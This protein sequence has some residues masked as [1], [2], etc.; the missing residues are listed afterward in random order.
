MCVDY[1]MLNSQ[2]IKD[3]FPL[4]HPEDL[5]DRMRDC[6]YFTKI[7]LLWGYWQI[8]VTPDH[9]HKTAFVTP[10]GQF[11]FRVLPFGLTNAPAT[12]QRYVAH[13]LCHD[14]DAGHVSQFID[15]ICVHSRTLDEH[16]VHVSSVLNTL[17]K[18]QLRTKPSKCDFF[19]K[20]IGFLGHTI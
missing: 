12:F 7:D 20:S 14:I 10:F 16:I 2:T 4:L 8:P 15:D 19:Q 18:N 5:F 9:H 1:R 17:A 11:Q 13:V 6:K 3:R